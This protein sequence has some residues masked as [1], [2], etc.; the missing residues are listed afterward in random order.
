LA[1]RGPRQQAARVVA[2]QTLDDKLGQTIEFPHSIRLADREHQR[3][4]FRG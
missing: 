1:R 3:E 2:A 4:P